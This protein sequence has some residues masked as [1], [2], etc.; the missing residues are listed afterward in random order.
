ML[1]FEKK[2]DLM[3]QLYKNLYARNIEIDRTISNYRRKR[4]PLNDQAQAAARGGDSYL[5]TLSVTW[6][7]KRFGHL[8]SEQVKQMYP[9][10]FPSAERTSLAA[11]SQLRFRIKT[12]NQRESRSLPPERAVGEAQDEN[13]NRLAALAK[14][15]ENTSR[16]VNYINEAPLES[17]RKSIEEPCERENPFSDRLFHMQRDDSQGYAPL[18]DR[19]RY[20]QRDE[21]NI[22][23]SMMSSQILEKRF[24]TPDLTKSIGKF[25]DCHSVQQPQ[26]LSSYSAIRVSNNTFYDTPLRNRGLKLKEYLPHVT[27]SGNLQQ[28]KEAKD[29]FTEGV[30]VTF[31]HNK[32]TKENKFAT[33]LREKE[34]VQVP[35][36]KFQEQLNEISLFK[37]MVTDPSNTTLEGFKGSLIK[38]KQPITATELRK[39]HQKTESPLVKKTL[40]TTSTKGA[41]KSPRSYL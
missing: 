22:R 23:G 38:A 36:L 35:P 14:E 29:F 4:K 12:N 11:I 1:D 10:I 40:L 6:L 26:Q 2:K 32:D 27:S 5:E 7:L 34:R 37:K 13:S 16:V 24:S 18:S 3:V 25:S 19:S 41:F 21:L 8:I 15:P 31:Y 30:A 33:T 28:I 39:S 20:G 17:E 9:H